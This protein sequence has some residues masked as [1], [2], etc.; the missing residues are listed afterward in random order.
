MSD[1]TR[2]VKKGLPA[3]VDDERRTAQHRTGE[4]LSR[5][6]IAGRSGERITKKGEKKKKKIW[7]FVFNCE[8]PSGRA[9]SLSAACAGRELGEEAVS[10]DRVGPI[11]SPPDFPPKR[12]EMMTLAE[13]LL[14]KTESW[15][16][17]GRRTQCRGVYRT[18]LSPTPLVG[19]YQIII[20]II[21]RYVYK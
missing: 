6:T 17:R 9:Q 13:K 19:V 1:W 4:N 21:I 20:I 5:V 16:A 8:K 7:N 14:G 11:T 3:V 15:R 10:Y 2:P 18:C 12:E